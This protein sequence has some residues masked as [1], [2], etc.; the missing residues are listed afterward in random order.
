MLNLSV[1]LED[2]AR[3][4]PDRA[5]G[6][7]HCHVARANPQWAE[8]V[9][10]PRVLAIFAGPHG[11]ISPVWYEETPHVPTW[12]F[13]VLHVHGRPEV[14]DPTDTY[15]V[16]SAT[17]HHLEDRFPEPWR[18]ARVDTYA[19]RIAAAVTGFRSAWRRI[20]RSASW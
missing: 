10:S 3:E 9:S 2:S 1:L 7:L 19:H 12:N 4:V 8:I 17:V 6:V 11:Y 5:A 18:L 13:S 16:L 14:L 15:D 20:S